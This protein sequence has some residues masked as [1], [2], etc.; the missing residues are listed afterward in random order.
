ME[1]HVAAAGEGPLVLLAHGFPELW[2]SWRHQIDPLVAAGYR[3]AA[4]DLRGYGGTSA[5]EA[6]DQYT[7][8]HLAGD[9]VALV[10][11][12]GAEQ[13]HVVGHD[14]GSAVAWHSALV[15][16]DVFPTVTGISVPFTPRNPAKR[17]IPT[18]TEIGKSRGGEFYMVHF[19]EP[20]VAE[21]EFE[22]DVERTFR[23]LSGAT[24]TPFVTPG[25]PMWDGVPVPDAL[26][27]WLTADDLAVY[28]EAFRAS[29]FRGPLNYYRNL[30][31]N[32]ELSAP[33]QGAVITQ[34]ALFI[35]GEHDPVRAFSAAAEANLTAAVPNLTEVVVVPG[36]GHW[37]Q[38]EAPEAVT[39]ALLAF[40]DKAPAIAG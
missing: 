9:L 28:V 27:D 11:A 21:A 7:L 40:L 6:I 10:R 32:W 2:Y 35:T 15:R 5:P 16:P 17:P 31:R 23:M 20:G 22:R 26:P 12:L 25:G 19:Q 33:W 39:T 38:Q 29:G 14:W 24:F 36:A 3:V 18:F 30:D 13:A 4:P 1:F 34:P 37:V 8:M